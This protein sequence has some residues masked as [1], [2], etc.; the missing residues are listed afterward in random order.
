[1][2]CQLAS[3]QLLI[4]WIPLKWQ[5]ITIQLKVIDIDIDI[6]SWCYLRH[7]PASKFLRRSAKIY[8]LKYNL[9][10]QEGD[11]AV[12]ECKIRKD[13]EDIN[14]IFKY[15]H[16]SFICQWAEQFIDSGDWDVIGTALKNWS[17]LTLSHYCD[18]KSGQFSLLL[19]L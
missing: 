11:T 2:K 13:S 19:R 12:I 6:D 4:T 15:F 3:I 18:N 8:V 10:F 16:F 14:A 17:F 1:M 5:T 7:L 9:V